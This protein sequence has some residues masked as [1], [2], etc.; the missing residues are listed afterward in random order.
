[1]NAFFR[2][3]GNS[4]A[5]LAAMLDEYLAN[6]GGAAGRALR[7]KIF[8]RVHEELSNATISR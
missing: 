2:M 3:T 8:R 4:S 5:D 7:K 6:S 1:L